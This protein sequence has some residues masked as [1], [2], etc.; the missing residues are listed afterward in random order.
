MSTGPNK[1]W[2]VPEEDNMSIGELAEWLLAL[3]KEIQHL[4]VHITND[5]Q[6]FKLN[7]SRMAVS[8]GLRYFSIGALSTMKTFNGL[9]LDIN[10]DNNGY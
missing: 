7:P 6:I 9:C 4:P 2:A 10:A 1:P 8:D 5:M 3:P